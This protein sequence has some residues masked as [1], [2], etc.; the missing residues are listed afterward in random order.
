MSEHIAQEKPESV[1]WMNAHE[2]L[3]RIERVKR[4]LFE[5]ANKGTFIP[6]AEIP[7]STSIPAEDIESLADDQL[8]SALNRQLGNIENDDRFI[9]IPVATIST[10]EFRR[11]WRVPRKPMELSQPPEAPISVQ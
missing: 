10:R 4:W 9:T 3:G 1:W 5:T 11:S 7:F 8:K 6:K 2:R